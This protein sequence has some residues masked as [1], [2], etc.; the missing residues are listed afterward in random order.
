MVSD[1]V[2]LIWKWSQIA[3]KKKNFFPIFAD[4]LKSIKNVFLNA[5]CDHFQISLTQS[6]TILSK[7]FV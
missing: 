3:F 1:W 4:G 2:K 7:I 5:I 6:E